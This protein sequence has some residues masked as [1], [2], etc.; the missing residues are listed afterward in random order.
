MVH[1]SIACLIYKSTTWLQFVYD[2]VRKYTDLNDKEFY[3][4]ANDANEKVIT[5]L[6][7]HNIPHYI[8]NNTE[9]QKKEWYINNVYRAY[10]TAC[11]E[12]KGEFTVL[13]NS[14]MA[15]SPNW[16]E[17]LLDNYNDSRIVN[18]RLV[19]RGVMS[20]GTYGIEC[21][22]GNIPS[23]YK[24]LDFIEYRKNISE[25]KLMPGG[26]FM[27]FI[28]KTKFLKEINYYPEG[29]IK[30]NSDIYNPIYAVQG[31]ALIPG[32]QVFIKKLNNIGIY[33][34]TDFNSIVYHFQEGEKRDTS[35]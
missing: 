20:S 14:D 25:K 27:P 35:E 1:I 12:S 17:S 13:I 2:Q 21:N 18:S 4:I 16:L 8:H 31:D 33:H 6:K 24:E 3:F 11:R 19:E 26:L 28:I 10:N 15:F 29:N 5:Y 32:D 7:E 9:E 22:F 34:Y 30:E 23:N